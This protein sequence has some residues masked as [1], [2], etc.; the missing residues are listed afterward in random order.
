MSLFE[1]IRGEAIDGRTDVY[2]LGCVLYE[3]L[4]GEP[5]FRDR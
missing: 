4:A 5:P 2:S 1:Q 3:C